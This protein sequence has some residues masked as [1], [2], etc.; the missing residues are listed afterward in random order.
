M[1]DSKI[2]IDHL[3]NLAKLDISSK[4]KEKLAEQLEATVDYIEILQELDTEDIKPTAQ[5]TGLENISDPDEAKPGLSQ[6]Q[7]LANAPKKKDGYF[8]VKK[9]KWEN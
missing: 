2:D 8:V 6:E 3:A 1:S 7:A 4:E 9:I 5:V